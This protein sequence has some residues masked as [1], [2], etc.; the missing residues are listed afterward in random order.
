VTIEINKIVKNDKRSLQSI[1]VAIYYAAKIRNHYEFSLLTWFHIP[2]AIMA[3]C[4]RLKNAQIMIAW[5]VP[6]D[7]SL[8]IAHPGALLLNYLFRGKCLNIEDTCYQKNC[9][10]PGYL[11]LAH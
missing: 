5:L 7:E 1:I 2:F 9:R 8:V 3:F 4:L 10:L 11:Q 6:V